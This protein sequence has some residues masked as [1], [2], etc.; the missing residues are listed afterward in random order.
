MISQHKIILYAYFSNGIGLASAFLNMILINKHAGVSVFGEL[1]LVTATSGFMSNLLTARSNESV[2]KFVSRED[3]RKKYSNVKS[4]LALGLSMDIIVALIFFIAVL[5]LSNPIAVLFKNPALSSPLILFSFVSISIFMQ[6]TPQGFLQGLAKYN[7]INSLKI[8]ESFL[9]TSFLLISLFLLHKNTLTAIILTQ[10]IATFGIT[11]FLYIIFFYYA[12]RY[13]IIHKS[14]NSGFNKNILHDIFSFNI[15]TFASTTLKAGHQNL[16]IILIN[17]FSDN[18]TTGIYKTLKQLF[19]PLQFISAPLSWIYFR[20]F[21]KQKEQGK[22]Q[23]VYRKII[24]VTSSLFVIGLLYSVVLFQFIP[25]ISYVMNIT[26]NQV[27]IYSMV[28]FIA[29]ISIFVLVGWWLRIFSNVYT[30]KLSLYLN[31]F[32][33]IYTAIFLSLLGYYFSYKG[34]L[35]GTLLLQV[36]LN[37]IGFFVLRKILIN[38]YL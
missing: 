1:A 35:A 14:L 7:L 12:T 23:Q 27:L 6:A 38:T 26:D 3:E 20:D 18:T 9:K 11:L 36:A 16:D 13:L 31:L 17:F 34:I 5:F 22:H 10:V 28:Y 24:S 29:S 33:V 37:C 30:P 32:A 21:S 15:I 25:Q 8:A 2:V 4:I 19:S